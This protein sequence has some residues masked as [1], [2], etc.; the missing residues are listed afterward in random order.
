MRVAAIVL[1]LSALLIAGVPH[2]NNC[3]YE[4]QALVLANGQ[5]TPP[6]CYWTAQGEIAL[7]I[8]LFGLALAVGVSRRR[9][10]RRFLGLVGALLGLSVIALPTKLIGTCSAA[11][12]SC[13]LIM[14]PSLILLGGL[15]STTSLGVIVAA[16]M[17]EPAG[18]AA[19]SADQPAAEST[20]PNRPAEG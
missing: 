19:P 14:K 7:A 6:R 3:Q 16:Q 18:D 5:S 17:Q 12:A 10:S 15:V 1:A 2:Y 9:G 13:N 8:P 4:G 20:Q 11:Q